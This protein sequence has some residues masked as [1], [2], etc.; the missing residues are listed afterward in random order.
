MFQSATIQTLY[1]RAHA[2]R[3][4]S[5]CP[6]DL[7]ETLNIPTTK[8]K[9]TQGPMNRVSFEFQGISSYQALYMQAVETKTGRHL[10]F[11]HEGVPAHCHPTSQNLASAIMAHPSSTTT[12]RRL[13][14]CTAH[15]ISDFSK[16]APIAQQKRSFSGV[17]PS[18]RSV[19]TSRPT[20]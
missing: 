5:V 20:P 12:D 19:G 11:T 4:Y 18:V 8:S 10:N 17:R 2:K 6:V 14:G 3:E 7:H 13:R 16:F 15:L 9:L 1:S